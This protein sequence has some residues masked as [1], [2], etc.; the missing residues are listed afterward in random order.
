MAGPSEAAAVRRRITQE[1][2]DE[3]VREN[4]EEFGMGRPEAV[5]DAVTQFQTQ[6]VELANIV[7]DT[8]GAGHPVLR[9]VATLRAFTASDADGPD[10]AAAAA[11]AGEALTVLAAEAAGNAANKAVAGTNDAV[12]L[13]QRAMDAFIDEGDHA[14]TRLAFDA[15]RALVLGNGAWRQ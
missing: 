10:D 1:T 15:L 11:A 2:F 4:M 5:A 13:V 8:T 3:V 7:K 14:R 6:G 9:A 12:L